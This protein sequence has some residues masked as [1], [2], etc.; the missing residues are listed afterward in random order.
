MAEMNPNHGVTQELHDQWH[1]VAMVLLNK[2]GKKQIKITMQDVQD[3]TKIFPG[4]QPVIMFNAKDDHILL[5]IISFSEAEKLAKQVG[6]L[7][8]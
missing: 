5:E 4:E 8:Y 7:P 6:G 1:K 2:L 3:L